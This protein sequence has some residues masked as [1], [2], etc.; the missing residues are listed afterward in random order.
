M[1]RSNDMN[2]HIHRLAGVAVL[3]LAACAWLAGCADDPVGGLAGAPT[4]GNTLQQADLNQPYGGL[5]YTDEPAAFGAT[6]LQAEAQLEMSAEADLDDDEQPLATRFGE[7]RSLLS[8]EDLR[9]TYVRI[10]W[11]RLEG[12]GG[13]LESPLAPLDWTGGLSVSDGALVVKHTI[14]FERRLQGDHLLPREDRRHVEW[15]SHTG[16]H[17]DG[18]VVCLLSRPDS[19]GQVAGTLEFRTPQ[20]SRSFEIAALA[21]LDETVLTDDQGNGVHFSALTREPLDCPSGFMAGRWFHVPDTAGGFFRG[22][23]LTESG[24]VRG[25]VMGRFGRN[26]AGEHVFAGKLIALDGRIRGLCEGTY[27]PNGDGTGTYAGHWANRAGTRM[28]EMAGRYKTRPVADA[29]RPTAGF[30]QGRWQEFCTEPAPL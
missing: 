29:E 14:L 25:F 4:E 18:I 13:A 12:E 1:H 24:R 5:A 8:Q 28:G 22:L 23:W 27:T 21:G 7:V 19:L 10:V 11:G 26:D 17:I 6:S 30:F 16:R 2:A 9:R 3:S 20:L 15:V